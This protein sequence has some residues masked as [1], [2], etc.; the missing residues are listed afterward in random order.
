[1]I[2]SVSG[3]WILWAKIHAALLVTVTYQGPPSSY[4]RHCRDAPAGCADR[5][6]RYAAYIVDAGRHHGVDPWLLAAISVRESGLNPHAI[7]PGGELGIMQINPRSKHARSLHA[8][9]VEPGDCMRSHVD[10]AAV[11]LARSITTC[12]H[13]DSGLGRYNTGRCVASRYARSVMLTRARLR[14]GH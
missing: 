2:T 14:D 12:G 7:G 10:T 9:C 8:P 6:A 13:V 5:T 1:M 3:S 11:I 4:V